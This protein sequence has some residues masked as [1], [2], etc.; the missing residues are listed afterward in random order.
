[1]TTNLEPPHFISSP[2]LPTTPI[3]NNPY[4]HAPTTITTPIILLFTLPEILVKI[5]AYL[6]PHQQRRLAGQVCYQWRTIVY[7]RFLSVTDK[8]FPTNVMEEGGGWGGGAHTALLAAPRIVDWILGSPHDKTDQECGEGD[9]RLLE[10]SG[11]EILR[12][13]VHRLRCFISTFEV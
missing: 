10:E 7:D 12:F 6:T 4:P 8:A 3:S 13:F 1:M 9:W 5:F 2:T 11:R